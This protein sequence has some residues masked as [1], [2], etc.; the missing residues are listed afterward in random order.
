MICSTGLVDDIAVE[1]HARFVEMGVI[2]RV[3]LMHCVSAYPAKLSDLNLRYI[4]TMI[5][6]F[7]CTIGYS[8]HSLGID[9]CKIALSLGAR[10]IEKHFT[11]DKNYSSFRDHS[12]SAEPE[13][14]AELVRF[15][16]SVDVS[17]GSELKPLSSD[18]THASA[19][20]RRGLYA[21][22]NLKAGDQLM[23]EDVI[24]LRPSAKSDISKLK[25]MVGKTITNNIR[26]GEEL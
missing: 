6:R 21:A 14:L 13:E 9:A 1:L 26:K 10:V 20:L 19:S 17:L 15:S 24:E 18:E 4:K 16:K 23:I 12:L 2:D 7:K 5:D 22:R 25:E 11:L 8:D 3:V